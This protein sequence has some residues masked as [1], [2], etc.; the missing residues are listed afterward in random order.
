MHYH[1]QTEL[2]QA[3]QDTKTKAVTDGVNQQIEAYVIIIIATR[4]R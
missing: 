2:S 3:D 4:S 1:I